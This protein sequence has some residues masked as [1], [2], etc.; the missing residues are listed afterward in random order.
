MKSPMLLI[1]LFVVLLAAIGTSSCAPQDKT[2]SPQTPTFSDGTLDGWVVVEGPETWTAGYN[3]D[4]HHWPR[5]DYDVSS[6]GPNGEEGIGTLRSAPFVINKDLQAFLIAGSDGTASSTNDGENNFLYLRSHPDGEIL[7][8]MHTPN[9]H[10]LKP[11]KWHTSELIGRKVYLE[12]TDNNPKLHPHG[13][14]WIGIA[15][16]QQKKQGSL[17]KPVQIDSLCGVKIDANAEKKVLRTIPFWVAPLKDRGQTKR[18][19]NEKTETIPLNTTAEAIYL[20]GMINHG[21]GSGV[22]FWSEHPELHKK[23]TDQLYIGAKI[24]RLEIRYTDEDSDEVPLV[25][26]ITS[27]FFQ[28]WSPQPLATRK[29]LAEQ[30]KKCVK[31]REISGPPSENQRYFLAIQPRKKIIESIII[32]DNPDFRGRPMV[33][34]ITVSTNQKAENLEP[35]GKCQADTDDLKPAVKSF[36][37]NRWAKEIKKLSD[38]LYTSKAQLPEKVERLHFP[39]DLNAAGIRFSGPVVADMLSNI[40]VANLTQIDEKFD[41]KT[42]F[43][44]E[45]TKG[46][47]SYGGYMG[48]G[49]WASIGSYA[50]WA[51][52]RCSDHYASLAL[53]CLDNEKRLT[54]YVDFCDKYLYYHRSDHDPKLGPANDKFNIDNYPK[55]APPHWAFIVNGPQDAV[56]GPVNEIAGNQE[57]DGHGAT[58]MGR[59]M[60]WRILGKPVDQW[61]MKPRENIYGKSR[62]D[63]TIDSTE[64]IC[65]LMDYTG[66]DVIY[67]EGETTAWGAGRLPEGMQTETNPAKIKQNYANAAMYEPYPTYVCLVA[68]RC[69]AQIADAVNDTDKATRWRSYAQRLE[70]GMVRLLATGDQSDRTWRM[71]PT[72]V[73]P[74]Q[75]ECMVQAWY[76]IYYD[77]LDPQRLH[78]EMTQISRNTFQRQLKLPTGHHPL[79]G[80]GYG[81]G[82]LTKSALILDEMDDA[83]K[84]LSNIA[85]YSYDKNMNYVDKEHNIDWRNW[86]WI[87]PEGVNLLPNGRW[88]RIGDLGNGANQ[89]IVLHAIELCAGIDD[90]KPSQLKII[91][92]VPAPLEGIE[93]TNF[94]VLV[95]NGKKLTRARINYSYDKKSGSFE[96]TSDRKLPNL[97]IRIGPYDQNTANDYAEKLNK[98]QKAAIRVE[99]SG[100]VYAQTAWW[101]W[102]EEMKNVDAVKL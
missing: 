99:A 4:F 75:Q 48:V 21:W 65:W 84:L 86:Q 22:A 102:I 27:G 77:G 54:S 89:G 24:G 36:R 97:A 37:K 28:W 38:I 44:G 49:A 45:S 101:I 34:A 59:W 95:P 31:L 23:R 82:W 15:D 12:I 88:H 40:W 16:Y 26:G 80:F 85:K 17:K 30:W 64:M 9:S 90:T 18:V 13:Y 67:S 1:L 93:V 39:A 52:S 72:S 87:I 91:P 8:K 78:K 96:L 69:S 3:P 6:L 7:R 76:S 73:Y 50:H 98:S 60:A 63:T 10:I 62:W 74:N 14:A 55:D 94:P 43:F 92:R 57:M 70:K 5:Q 56:P 46:A 71:G 61:L 25:M 19:V 68:L 83:G 51:F 42:G 33:S 11:A 32:H 66:M 29:E 53:R 100:N 79:V 41:A 2:I 81:M 58:V 35:F 47:P 20:L